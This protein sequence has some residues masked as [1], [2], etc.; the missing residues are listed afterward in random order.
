MNSAVFSRFSDH[1]RACYP[2][3]CCG[4]LVD[5]NGKA[6]YFACKNTAADPLQDFRIAPEDYAKAEDYGAILGICHSHPD[7][8]TKPSDRDLAMCEASGLPWHI[9][10]W[11]EGDLRTIVPTGAIP[12]LVGR[13][14]V[15]GAWDCYALVR[16]WYRLERSITLP[17]FEREDG[18]WE[19]EQDL[20]LDNYAKAGFAAV[21][22]DLQVGDVILMRVAAKRVNHAA[23]YLGNG[24]INHHLY[25]QLSTKELYSDKWQKRTALVVRHNP[26]LTA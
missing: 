7:A 23:V 1:A 15:H 9:T 24:E 25:G 5:I 12:P 6:Q 4:L 18:W 17:N 16:D 11:P 3:E 8:T 13:P 21:S 22:G 10:S 20:Y 2:E 26:M 19:G 14:F